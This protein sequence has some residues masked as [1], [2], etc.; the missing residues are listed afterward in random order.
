MPDFLE[1]SPRHD[2]ARATA[3][4]APIAAIASWER[5]RPPTSSRRLYA[6]SGSSVARRSRSATRSS[7]GNRHPRR[8]LRPAA[9]RPRRARARSARRAR[10]RR[11]PRPRRRRPGPQ[12]RDDAGRDVASSSRSSRSRTCP[13]RGS[14]SIVTREPSTRSRSGDST[15]RSSSS[16]PTSSRRSSA[17][18][19]PQR[20]LELV[21]LA[22]AMR[23][24]VSRAEVDA[25]R[26]R[27]DAG[28]R[29]VEFEMAPVAVSSSE[30]RA[31]VERGET[32]AA[33]VSAT[34]ADAIAR[35][36]L[37]ASPE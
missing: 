12:D 25:V 7:S 21:R 5:R 13:K 16:E 23:P 17:G 18:S 9:R 4:F 15:T 6:R 8:R 19:R 22:V 32:I 27:L 24:G 20:V 29:I 10:A 31:R 26:R 28:D 36:G 2:A 3:S 33:D 34:V 30:I 1:Y 11:D 37:Y 14:S 35:L